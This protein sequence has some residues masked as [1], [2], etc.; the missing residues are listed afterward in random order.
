MAP[1]SMAPMRLRWALLLSACG[2]KV[3]VDAGPLP[4]GG[5][6][7]GS[8]VAS[9]SAGSVG[10]STSGGTGGSSG[11]KPP[12]ADDPDDA[13]D[14]VSDRF[15]CP[16]PAESIVD[17]AAGQALELHVVGVYETESEHSFNCHPA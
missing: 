6:G 16:D 1:G 12:P 3:V 4:A 14:V 5:A 2:G 7:G 10:S 13:C 11:D 15:L 17:Q 9:S 8:A